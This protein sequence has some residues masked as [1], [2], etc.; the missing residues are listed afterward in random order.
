[1]QQK[2]KKSRW[3]FTKGLGVLGWFCLA[4]LPAMAASQENDYPNHPIRYILANGP[5]S[6]ADLFTRIVAQQLSE[7]LHQPVVVDTRPGAGG[8]LGMGLMAKA[9]PDGYTMGRG[10][11]P[12]LAIAPQVYKSVP[13][14]VKTDFI[15]VTLTDLGQ[16]LLVVHL[17]VPAHSVRELIQLL[18]NKPDSFSM[19]SPGVGS[20]G[21]L[22]GLL[23]TSLGHVTSLHVP[24]KSAGVSTLSVVANE[25]QWTF[26]PIGAPLPHVR[27]GRL[28][29][30]AVGGETRASQLP[31]IPTVVEAGVADYYCSNW[32]G[33]VM[34]RGTPSSRVTKINKAVREILSRAEIKTQFEQQ[35]AEAF[36]STPQYFEKLIRED[37]ERARKLIK[38]AKLVP[39]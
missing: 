7:S 2:N 27:S 33:I 15:A 34:P 18:K 35:G 10:S 11:F 14:D 16:N 22:A 1:M 32:A 23:L 31:D 17:G 8:T 12:V 3:V 6:N 37:F 5:G 9:A 36:A 19:A 24:Y 4:S 26:T 28:R 29:A 21:H 13:Y 39:E 38:L 30:L 20:V 25:T